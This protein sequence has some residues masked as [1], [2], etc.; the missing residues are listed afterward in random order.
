M[1]FLTSPAKGLAPFGHAVIPLSLCDCASA[2]TASKTNVG[3]V[4]RPLR[5]A[6]IGLLLLLGSSYLLRATRPREDPLT[7][8]SVPNG[9]PRNLGRGFAVGNLF[10][11]EA[12]ITGEAFLAIPVCS[13]LPDVALVSANPDEGSGIKLSSNRFSYWFKFPIDLTIS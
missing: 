11:L 10:D 4:L 9:N 6:C 8:L 13:I 12:V 5:I 7:S 2:L 3:I 1:L